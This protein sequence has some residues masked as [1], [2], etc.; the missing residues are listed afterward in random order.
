MTGLL[1]DT[2]NDRADAAGYPHLDLDAIIETGDR[3]VRRRRLAAVG[4]AAVVAAAVV[5]AVAIGPSALDRDS[6]QLPPVGQPAGPFA[7]ARPTYA[8]GSTIHYGDQSLELD[9]P[10]RSFVQTPAGFV[11]TGPDGQV[12]FT[13]GLSETQIGTTQS[14]GRQLA[15]DSSGPYVGWVDSTDQGAPAFV[16]YDTA[17]GEEVVR[18]TEGSLAGSAQNDPDTV[19]VMIAI[20]NGIAYWH[21][22]SG[23]KAYDVASGTLATVKEGAD[24]E[25]LDDVE[26]GV[27]SHSSDLRYLGDAGDQRII[28]S[29]D[30]DATDPGFAR[31]NHGYLPPDG[32]HVAVSG[33]DVSKV[34]DVATRADVTPPHPGYW[35]VSF[36]Q[37]V[38]DDTF[39]YL[40]FPGES[41]TYR[42]ADLLTCSISQ[43]SCEVA[44]GDVTGTDRD[45]VVF[46]DMP[47]G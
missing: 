44:F 24:A 34:I 5:A 43:Q 17:K 46:P 29:S 23:V 47:I 33:G 8:S 19:S 28:V 27:L 15:S 25:W 41:P 4:G 35:V 11:Y 1:R 36:G 22:G 37:W 18:T 21:D 12:L 13:D 45:P 2:M 26:N 38:D 32:Q 9:H 6:G 10:V 30:P 16:V 31:W 7:Q 14:E 20:D 40:A 42:T 39:T 3:R